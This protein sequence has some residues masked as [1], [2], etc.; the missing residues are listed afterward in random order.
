[1][2]G[3]QG[4]STHTPG[5]KRKARKSDGSNIFDIAIDSDEAAIHELD[6][7]DSS[8]VIEDKEDRKRLCTPNAKE[9][10]K[11]KKLKKAEKKRVK[12]K[13]RVNVISTEDVKRI[14][15]AIHPLTGGTLGTKSHSRQNSGDLMDNMI[16]MDNIG[17]VSHT[18]EYYN[19]QVRREY[20]AK[21]AAKAKGGPQTPSPTIG[22]TIDILGRLNIQ[23]TVISASK[24]RRGLLAKLR[25]AIRNDI[26]TVE[27]EDRETMMRK[28]GYFRYASRRA[29]NAMIRNNQIWDWVSG[30]KLDEVD[31]EDEESD[32]TAIGNGE[33][34]AAQK[35][36]E[37]YGEDFVFEGDQL[38][39]VE[40]YVATE[41]LYEDDGAH[42][43]TNI[44]QATTG[45][46][47]GPGS[48]AP[49]VLE[50]PVRGGAIHHLQEDG[51]DHLETN[52]SKTSTDLL[53]DPG[54]PDLLVP[55]HWD[56]EDIIDTSYS[57]TNFKPESL[58]D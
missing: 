22:E 43:K 34:V 46:L 30:C 31:E 55:E 9:S 4:F 36:I 50:K 8:S 13:S 42:L 33:A 16:I 20:G 19:S 10:K 57:I 54:S 28:A 48:P 58:Y 29:Y 11:D 15:E 44:P 25:E 27:N 45:L 2:D 53:T 24:E 56:D 40:R 35:V 37:D 18:F 32:E 1:M 7:A 14:A 52:I 23:T 47:T 41:H 6:W 39:L 26:T 17:F 12:S 5:N 49:S 21:K 3:T 51:D 38:E